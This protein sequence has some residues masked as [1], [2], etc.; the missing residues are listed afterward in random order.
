MLDPLPSFKTF[1]EFFYVRFSRGCLQPRIIL[2]DLHIALQRKLKADARPVA[3]PED[4]RTV[5][6][7]A[8]VSLS[9][10]LNLDR[11]IDSDLNARPVLQCRA[12]FFQTIDDA[13]SIWIK[14]REFTI[15]RMLGDYYRSKA[16]E[17]DGG[18]L[19]IFRLAPQD[20]HRYHSVRFS[21]RPFC[22]RGAPADAFACS[23]SMVSWA[24]TSTSVGNTTRVRAT[25]DC[26][27][28][29]A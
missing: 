1:N 28:C 7:C 27:C 19:A 9:P 10:D 15:G 11:S 21:G 2:T 23:R 14:G 12:M 18:S 24:S 17:Y 20:Y 25:F 5:V 26:L 13:T 16:P 29:A 22:M 6:S 8:D 3:D 4:P